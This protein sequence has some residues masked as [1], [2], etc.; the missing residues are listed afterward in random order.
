MLWKWGLIGIGLPTVLPNTKCIW[1][2]PILPWHLT[3]ETLECTTVT[4]I[5]MMAWTLDRA[6][7]QRTGRASIIA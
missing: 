1:D 4:S 3:V 6:I 5:L 7:E 2:P